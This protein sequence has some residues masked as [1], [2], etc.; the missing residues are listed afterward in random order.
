MLVL[1]GRLDARFEDSYWLI[2][3]WSNEISGTTM[4]GES[5]FELH[6]SNAFGPQVNRYR[7][8]TSGTRRGDATNGSS[9]IAPSCRCPT[10]TR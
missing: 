9:S 5:N 1:T 3:A 2:S 6:F 4:S 7:A 10:E 8:A